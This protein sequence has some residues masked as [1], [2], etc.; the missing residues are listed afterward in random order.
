MKTSRNGKAKSA[1]KR[2]G[3]AVLA[4]LVGSGVGA[5]AVLAAGGKPAFSIAAS[6][7]SQTLSRGQA[8]TYS[9]T[10]TRLN[11]F[12]SPVSLSVTNLPPRATASWMLSDGTTSS[13]VPPNLNGATLTIQTASTTPVAT[14]QPVIKATSGDLTRR[15]RVTLVV[16]SAS[17][18][19]FT[20]APDPAS[21]SVL[22]GDPTL[23]KVKVHRTGG[24]SGPVSLSVAGL[25]QGATGFWKPSDTVPSGRKV[26]RL[27]IRTAR[28]TPTG[29]YDLTIAGAATINGDTVSRSAAV[30][31][32]VETGQDFQ[33]AGNLGT[34][35]APGMKAPLDL[36][37][38]NPHPFD[39]EITNLTVA[40]EDGTSR[41]G[42][43]G[44]Q[45]F[46]ITPIP[47]ARYPITLPAGQTK[48]LGE[49]GVAEGDQPQ[50]EMLDQPWNQDDCKNATITLDY[51][52][53]AGR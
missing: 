50:V 37:V 43:S 46:G 47:A 17:Q 3:L 32:V 2:L 19:N 12:A 26:A 33:I 20:L 34:P 53:S 38:T 44:T 4:I 18:P 39:L 27:R 16:Q 42:C 31:L 41:T 28:D 8:T 23:Y 48:S 45:N 49:L 25:P 1:R 40:V 30:T 7:A 52:G 11:G 29:S 6:P 15:T 35:L 9:V 10:V 51:D 21:Q 13:V 22:Q 24:F 14:S 36:T 5:Y